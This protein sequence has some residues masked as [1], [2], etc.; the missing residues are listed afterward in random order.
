MGT[1]FW[2]HSEEPRSDPDDEESSP[3]SKRLRARFLAE[4][5]LS[6]QSEIL[7]Y[8]QDDGE[9][10][11]MAGEKHPGFFGAKNGP[12]IDTTVSS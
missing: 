1:R 2:C 3:A 7:R 9:G 12:Q 5:T 8:A 6:A 4:F 11:G 10:L